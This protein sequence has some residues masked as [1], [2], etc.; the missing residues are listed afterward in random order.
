MASNESAVPDLDLSL[1]ELE[2]IMDDDMGMDPEPEPEPVA[3]KKARVDQEEHTPANQKPGWSQA[4][5]SSGTPNQNTKKQTSEWAKDSSTN[6]Q[7]RLGQGDFNGFNGKQ[8]LN[9]NKNGSSTSGQTLSETLKHQST[10]NQTPE[11]GNSSSTYQNKPSHQ[12]KKSS[13]NQMEKWDCQ[14]EVKDEEVSFVVG[15]FLFC[16]H[17]M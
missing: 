17:V 7:Q 3:N 12:E 6:K 9:Q 5:T 1:E 11:T 16:H 4:K 15:I 10:K 2:S 13:T 8:G 14:E